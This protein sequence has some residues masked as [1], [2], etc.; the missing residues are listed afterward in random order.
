M[1]TK[2]FVAVLALIVAAAV[3]TE[4]KVRRPSRS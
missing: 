4:A 2:V 3:V 1:E